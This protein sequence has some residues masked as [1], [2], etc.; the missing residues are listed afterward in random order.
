MLTGREA[1]QSG[2][3]D[4]LTPGPL[5][6]DQSIRLNQ[7]LNQFGLVAQADQRWWQLSTGLQRAF[8][9]LRAIIKQPPLLLLDEPFQAMDAG[10]HA[11][12]RDWL[13]TELSP[14]QTLVI[15]THDDAELPRC[16]NRKLMLNE[17]SILRYNELR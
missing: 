10:L 3:A 17:G 12:C 4:T 8:L 16:V 2:Y 7:L 6:S 13:D 11:R 15:V 14:D 9:F 1:V 5:T